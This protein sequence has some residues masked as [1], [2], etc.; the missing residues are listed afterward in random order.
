MLS[1]EEMRKRNPKLRD[2][3]DE[4]L[5][6]ARDLLYD[7]ARLALKIW[8]IRKSGSNKIVSGSLVEINDVSKYSACNLEKQK[9]E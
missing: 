8:R 1:L 2:V 9:T 4:H 5:E 6:H 7:Q 3:S